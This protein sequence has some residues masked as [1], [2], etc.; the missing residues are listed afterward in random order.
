MR[1]CFCV[2]LLAACSQAPRRKR[3]VLTGQEEGSKMCSLPHEAERGEW[4]KSRGRTLPSCLPPQAFQPSRDPRCCSAPRRRGLW[5]ATVALGVR[6]L[7]D[8]AVAPV[9]ASIVCGIFSSPPHPPS[10]LLTKILINDRSF[11]IVKFLF[12]HPVSNHQ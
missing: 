2:F 11:L 4:L 12:L 6:H 10:L 8:F 9:A 3:K 7:M 1:S 5:R